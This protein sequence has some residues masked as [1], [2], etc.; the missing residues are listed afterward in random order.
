[1]ESGTVGYGKWD[2]RVWKVGPLRPLKKGHNA[3]YIKAS[4]HKNTAELSIY[5][6][7]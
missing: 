4:A 3:I 1:M 7:L 6:L 5:K 2:R